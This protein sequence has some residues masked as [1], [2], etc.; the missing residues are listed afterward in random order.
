MIMFTVVLLVIAKLEV[1]KCP[2]KAQGKNK[3]CYN[4]IE[5]YTAVKMSGV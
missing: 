4:S 3:W 5:Y 1:S 2:S